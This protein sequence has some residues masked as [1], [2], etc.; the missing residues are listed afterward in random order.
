MENLEEIP[1]YHS[2]NVSPTSSRPSTAEK[3]KRL[4]LEEENCL[5]TLNELE[6][7][8]PPLSI[9]MPILPMMSRLSWGSNTDERITIDKQGYNHV[10]AGL[11]E[12]FLSVSLDKS[13]LYGSLINSSS[14]H[15][16]TRPVK[17]TRKRLTVILDLDE[18]LVHTFKPKWKRKPELKDEGKEEEDD[19]DDGETTQNPLK[20]FFVIDDNGEKLQVNV[21]PG[22][23]E[24]LAKASARFE[25][26][27]WT[28]GNRSY[29]TQV[30]NQID[31]DGTIFSG[32]MFRD[33]CIEKNG[34][35]LKDLRKVPNV[36]LTRTV[37]VDNNPLSYV[38]QPRNGIHIANFFN[39]ASDKTLFSL[40]KLLVALDEIDDVRTEL[41]SSSATADEAAAVALNSWR[42]GDY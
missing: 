39:D 15:C 21:R 30:I 18:T 5:D 35:Y 14:S 11:L 33:S 10:R 17:K 38:F 26:R 8:N 41:N 25:V 3:R 12:Q 28:A 19:V 24:F 16:A 6:D 23:F 34:L 4:D 2:P 22:L 7:H 40:M 9:M 37:L 31:P 36:D 20:Y 42:S 29:A 27:L 32:Q 1:S 13:V